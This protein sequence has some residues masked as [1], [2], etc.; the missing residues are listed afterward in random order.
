MDFSAADGWGGKRGYELLGKIQALQTLL[1][2]F[3][4]SVNAYCYYYQLVVSYLIL[5]CSQV[6]IF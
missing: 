2:N 5:C 4:L 6:L 1:K 3:V